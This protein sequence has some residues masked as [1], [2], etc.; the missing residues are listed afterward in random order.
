MSNQAQ[1]TYNSL[2]SSIDTFFVPHAE[3]NHL[4]AQDI[5]SG[6]ISSS[7]NISEATFQCFDSNNELMIDGSVVAGLILEIKTNLE[8][9]EK[10]LPLAFKGEEI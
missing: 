5:V 3:A 4:N 6:L 7:M 2:L 1:K 9:I 10:I 8:M